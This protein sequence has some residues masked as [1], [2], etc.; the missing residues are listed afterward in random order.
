MNTNVVNIMAIDGFANEEIMEF[1]RKMADAGSGCE[2]FLRKPE[3]VAALIDYMPYAVAVLITKPFLDG[4]LKKAGE[5]AYVQLKASIASLIERIR[6]KKA[7]YYASSDNK[8]P[9]APAH[10]RC[11]AI[12]SVD[13]EGHSVKFLFAYSGSLDDLRAS[14]DV[15]CE[16]I[17]SG[18]MP[19]V[20]ARV[21]GNVRLL[22][23]DARDVA[24]KSEERLG[25]PMV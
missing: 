13:G 25:P 24:W 16:H 21:V 8:V 4:F 20:K 23:F 2:M 6:A 19:G 12:H 1:R 15:M 18:Q 10:S 7:L 3:P 5:D 22:Y 11:I 9:P 17:H 14:V